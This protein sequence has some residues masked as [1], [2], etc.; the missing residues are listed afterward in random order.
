M[1]ETAKILCVGHGAEVRGQWQ[2]GLFALVSMDLVQTF[3]D[4]AQ[5]KLSPFK[6]GAIDVG[7]V[8]LLVV[9]RTWGG[10]GSLDC[11]FVMRAGLLARFVRWYNHTLERLWR[12][13]ISR[14]DAPIYRFFGKPFVEGQCIPRLTLANLLYRLRI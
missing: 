2:G 12:P 5:R 3:S 14:I 13:V 9:G 8:R 10:D 7:G 6:R 1:K 11:C 4:E